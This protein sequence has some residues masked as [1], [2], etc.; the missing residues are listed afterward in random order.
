MSALCSHNQR[1]FCLALRLLT[2]RSHPH[3]YQ[4]HPQRLHRHRS[5]FMAAQAWRIT[6][7]DQQ[8]PHRAV[9]RN[10][11]TGRCGLEY[12]MEFVSEGHTDPNITHAGTAQ[13]FSA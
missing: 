10:D 13:A 2:A 1:L 7:H 12:S 11:V 3:P 9:L 5:G 4:T 8:H 6:P